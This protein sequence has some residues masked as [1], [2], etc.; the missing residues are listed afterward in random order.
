MP[1]PQI[2]TLP[3][4]PVRGDRLNFPTVADEFV[5]ALPGFV[6]Q[7]NA[8]SSFAEARANE[9]ETAAEGAEAAAEAASNFADIAGAVAAF[10]GVWEDLTGPL[11]QPAAVFHDDL[12][13]ILLED[14]ADVT[15][16]EPGVSVVWG[17]FRDDYLPTVGGQAEDLEVDGLTLTGEVT[18][19]VF[20][21]TGT[22]PAINAT[23]GTIQTWMMTAASTPTITLAAGQS[24]TLMIGDAVHTITW[25]TIR[26]VGSGGLPPL[27][28]TTGYNVITLW[29]VGADIFGSYGGAG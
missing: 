1:A 14:L 11:A 13:W 27:L 4:A 29:R 3:P 16:H 7:A 25:P 26:W 20:A 28:A 6:T 21:I 22:T 18:E 12:Y 24:I 19:S 23:N 15:A 2:D 9:A 8:V 10:A 5:A 17:E